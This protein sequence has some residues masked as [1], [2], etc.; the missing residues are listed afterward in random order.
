[1]SQT[2]AVATTT[3]MKEISH[4]ASLIRLN[5]RNRPSRAQV[6]ARVSAQTQSKQERD[7]LLSRLVAKLH[8]SNKVYHNIMDKLSPRPRP[9]SQNKK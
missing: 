6:S 1:M 3:P 9:T 2:V 7:A 4:R 5:H 8:P